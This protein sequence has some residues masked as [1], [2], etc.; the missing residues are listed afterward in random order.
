M[1]MGFSEAANTAQNML[2][3]S[4]R[5]RPTLERDRLPSSAVDDI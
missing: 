2:S 1:A 3:Q 4:V 5:G